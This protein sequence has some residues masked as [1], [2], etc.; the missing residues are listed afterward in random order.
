MLVGSA[1]QVKR[2]LIVVD[3]LEHGHVVGCLL[4]LVE[5]LLEA[6]LGVVMVQGELVATAHNHCLV[7]RLQRLLC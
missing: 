5:L 4:V 1:L 2:V 7:G 3:N 6:A